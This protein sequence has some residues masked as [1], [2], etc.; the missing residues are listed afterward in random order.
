[1]RRMGIYSRDD[2]FSSSSSSLLLEFS[3]LPA[4]LAAVPTCAAAALPSSSSSAA[5]SFD[6]VSFSLVLP[7]L[8][9]RAMPPFPLRLL[10]GDDGEG[11][12][13]VV[14]SAVGCF[15]PSPPPESSASASA[16]ASLALDFCVAVPDGNADSRS[17]LRRRRLPRFV[18]ARAMGD[19]ESAQRSSPSWEAAHR[20]AMAVQCRKRRNAVICCGVSF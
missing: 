9:P 16:S 7:P 2:S 8:P 4:A 6:G 15:F 13:T 11:V 17:A 10:F 14:S 5:F 1:M 20:S 3:L 18:L 12:A 19:G